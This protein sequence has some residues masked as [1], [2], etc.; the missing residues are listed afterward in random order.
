M[1]FFSAFSC[2]VCLPFMLIHF[3]PMSARQVLFLLLAGLC[4]CVGQFGITQAYIYAPAKEI[5]VYDYTQ[6]IFTAL[7][8][9]AFFAQVPDILSVLGYVLICASGVGMFFYNKKHG[10]QTEKKRRIEYG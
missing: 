10:V 1:L 2:I 8:G 9:F 7:L 3:E 5:S 6:V 4:A